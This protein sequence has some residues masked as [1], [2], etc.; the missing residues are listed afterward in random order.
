MSVEEEVYENPDLRD[1]IYSFVYLGKKIK[2]G[3]SDHISFFGKKM[4][5]DQGDRVEQI[6]MDTIQ[7]LAKC[8]PNGKGFTETVVFKKHFKKF[9]KNVYLYPLGWV[10]K[11][12]S[13]VLS[14]F[15]QTS[16]TYSVPPFITFLDAH[17]V[18]SRIKKK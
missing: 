2:N 13:S 11:S 10:V 6:E 15:A 18:K 4:Y 5:F 1:Y 7:Y 14:Y 8:I 3:N 9:F 16:H 12:P 17:S